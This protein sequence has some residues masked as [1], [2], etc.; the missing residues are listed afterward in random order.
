MINF[1]LPTVSILPILYSFRRCPYAM[2]AR[3]ALGLAGIAYQTVEVSLRA[4]PPELLA[5]S[6]KGT[7]P[8]MQLPDGTVL[9]QSLDIMRWALAQN[10]PEGWLTAADANEINH[11]ITL[12]DDRFKPLLDRYKYANRHPELSITQHRALAMDAF[13]LKLEAALQASWDQAC[14]PTP[15]TNAYLCGLRATLAD[16]ATFPFVRQFA[17]VDQAWFDA[18]PLPAV[19]AWLSRWLASDLFATIMKK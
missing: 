6:P 15:A 10:D 17:A 8:V 2:R 11:W 13:I 1:T 7:V 12:C 14:Q 4:K 16:A 9:E 19:Q 3:L 5:I 18:Q